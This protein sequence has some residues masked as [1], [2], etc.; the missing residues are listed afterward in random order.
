MADPIVIPNCYI[1]GIEM[2]SG[3]QSVINVV[4][5]RGTSS[6]AEIVA[7]QVKNA[8]ELTAGPLSQRPTQLTMK[9]YRVTDIGS[10]VGP[11]VF[12]GSS[13]TGL[14]TGQLATNG[15]CALISYSGGTRSR[16]SSGRMYHGPLQEGDIN[17][18]GRTMAPTRLASL[19]Q[20]YNVFRNTLLANDLEWVV[21]S[22]KL[23][24]AFSVKAPSC[25]SVI[26]TQRR[27]IRGR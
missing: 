18:D 13:K 11:V 1:V 17:T 8:W 5:V 10:A 22:R 23:Q 25:Q 27:R 4:G 15:A 20:T 3:G 6:S 12:L 7:N 9:G 26:A 24:Q 14:T 19:T 16:S 2:E 21:I